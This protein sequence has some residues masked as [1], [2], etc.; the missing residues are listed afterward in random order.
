MALGSLGTQ[1]YISV[2]SPDSRS[3]V[4]IEIES[5]GYTG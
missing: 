4:G 3:E 2:E 1:A 5:E